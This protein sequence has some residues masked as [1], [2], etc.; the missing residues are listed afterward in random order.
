M[1]RERRGWG[2]M[3]WKRRVGMP[4]RA[5]MR[6]VRAWYQNGKGYAEV[7]RMVGSQIRRVKNRMRRR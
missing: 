1:A 5:R 3:R 4:E 2:A 7:A 6:R